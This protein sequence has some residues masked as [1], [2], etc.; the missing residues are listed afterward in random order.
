M[1]YAGYLVSA[2]TGSTNAHQRSSYMCWDE[3][4]EVG[5]G[6]TSQDQA[7]IYPVEVHCGSLPCS[8]YVTGTELTCVVCSK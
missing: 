7:L 3:S 8:L 5:D 4:P 1:E 2:W 6:G